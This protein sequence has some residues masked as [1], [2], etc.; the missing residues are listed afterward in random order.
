LSGRSIPGTTP[1]MAAQG[2]SPNQRR[3]LP[4]DAW[5][6]LDTF[7]RPRPSR[8]MVI[9]S[10]DRKTGSAILGEIAYHRSASGA[11]VS[12][13]EAGDSPADRDAISSGLPPSWWVLRTSDDLAPIA[14]TAAA[15]RLI[16]TLVRE[17]GNEPM[18]PAL[19]LPPPILEGY[20]LLPRA[21]EVTLAVNSWDGL[22][23]AYLRGRRSNEGEAPAEEDLERI[24]LRSSED[25]LTVHLIVVTRRPRPV[26]ESGADFVIEVME[27]ARGRPVSV[28][29][30]AVSPDRKESDF[31]P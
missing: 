9:R 21:P 3:I 19:W 13:P 14:A 15:L 7:F 20:S 27:P 8:V 16:D 12:V 24:L 2:E 25:Y 6:T 11:V 1:S 23:E 22:M 29:V 17:A 18:V 10:T 4:A 28:K 30:R 26:L 5:R 31:P